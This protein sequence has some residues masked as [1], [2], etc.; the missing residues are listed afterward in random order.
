MVRLHGLLRGQRLGVQPL[1]HPRQ[2]HHRPHG[3]HH[4]P[5]RQRAGPH[6]FGRH[7]PVPDQRKKPPRPLADHRRPDG[8][9]RHG[10]GKLL[11]L[12]A[13][14]HLRLA[15]RPPALGLFR[16]RARRL[17]HPVDHRRGTD[18][19]H[20]LH[21]SRGQERRG[22]RHQLQDRRSA[23]LGLQAGLRPRRPARRLHRGRRH[24]R[25]GLS[26]SLPAGPLHA[27]LHLQ[28]HH[29]RFGHRG[30]P[31]RSFPE[32]HLLR[33]VGLRGRHHRL[34]RRRGAWGSGPRHRLYQ[35]LQHHLRQARLPAR[36]RAPARHGGELWLQRELQVRRFHDLQLRLPGECR[37]RRRPGLGGRGAGRSP[38]HPAAHGDDRRRGGQWR[39]DDE[40][41]TRQAHRKLHGRIHAY[42]GDQR[43]PAGHAARHRRI[44]RARHV[45]NCAVRHRLA[46]GH[47]RL[48]RLRQDRLRR[49]QRRQIR[50]HQRLV[51]GLHPR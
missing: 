9:E 33:F 25:H 21:L 50:A 32:V 29:P 31:Q 5:R 24:R 17:Q 19:L 6:R 11:F 46:R 7:A 18:G 10:R 51:R 14:Q 8:H 39:R 37:K 41:R 40:A 12:H 42:H 27:R 49:D 44:A 48:H 38:R 23:C 43:L 30:R 26:Q 20:L 36:R 22:L 16:R 1:Q 28:D 3:R 35:E 47:L 45:R 15:P 4:R 13:P 34:R 2:R